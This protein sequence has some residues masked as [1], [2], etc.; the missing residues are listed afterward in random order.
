MAGD[1]MIPE[2][3]PITYY[4]VRTSS[5][6]L[7]CHWCGIDLSTASRLTYLNGNLPCCDL[8]LYKAQPIKKE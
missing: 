4:Q 7:N 5:S 6:I 8:C 1:Y 2:W 3:Q